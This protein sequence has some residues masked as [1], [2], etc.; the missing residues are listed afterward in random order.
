MTTAVKQ[1]RSKAKPGAAR[2]KMS[3]AE[4][5]AFIQEDQKGDLID[6]VAKIMSPATYQHEDLQGFLAFLLRGYVT[7]V[8]LGKVLGSRSLVHIDERNGY[9]PDLLF[10]ARERLGI[11]HDLEIIEGPDLVVEIVSP[12]SRTDD[13]A[14]K[15][16][17]YERA[18]VGEYWI[19]DPLREEAT[20]YVRREERL[21]EVH[22][23]GGTFRSEAVPGFYLR[24]EWIF[25]EEK[26]DELALLEEM[27]KRPL[28]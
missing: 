16:T 10:V 21:E 7:S 1:S 15:F 25:T 27:L 5:M 23:E 24:P 9:E 3:Y 22:P 13:Y 11:I 19:I 8:G 18:G 14:R 28:K 4:F 12:S 20:F 6:G 26:P 2:R 17:G